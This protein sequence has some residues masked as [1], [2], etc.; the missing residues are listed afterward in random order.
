MIPCHEHAAHAI[1]ITAAAQGLLEVGYAVL[2]ALLGESER[3]HACQV[4]DELISNGR[5]SDQGDWGFGIHPLLS[6]DTR[7]CPL[8]AHP[9]VTAVCEAALGGRIHLKHAGSRVE[10]AGRN[11]RAA[12]ISWHNHAFTPSLRDIQPGDPRRGRR[13]VRLLYGWYLDGSSPEVGSLVVLPRCWDEPLAPP[14]RPGHEP[15]PHEVALRAPPGSAVLFTSDL[16]HC[17]TTGSLTRCRRLTGAH[18]QDARHS[19]PHPEDHDFSGAELAQARLHHPAFAQL[20]PQGVRPA[21]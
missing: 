9:L 5:C 2:P 4:H 19:E 10:V 8:F 13:P 14:L 1:D 3:A 11:A 20:T 21:S 17:A 15:W 6:I 12:R 16:W 7:L 18:V